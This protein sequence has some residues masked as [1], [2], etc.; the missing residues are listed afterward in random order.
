MTLVVMAQ[1]T[2]VLVINF[3]YDNGIITL[4]DKTIMLGYY[5]DRNFQPEFGHRLEILSETNAK[6]YSFIRLNETDFSLI[7]PYFDNAKE[8]NI[9]NE[10]NYKVAA[11]I[12][13]EEQFAP[14]NAAPWYVVIAFILVIIIYFL[15]K[16]KKLP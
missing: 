8:I 1:E 13:K 9:Y 11:F 14:Q 2:D 16:K 15:I 7:V 10:R 3:H 4:N 5:P 6:L 12:I